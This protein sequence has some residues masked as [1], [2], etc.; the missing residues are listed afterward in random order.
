[1]RIIVSLGFFAALAMFAPSPASAQ[2]GDLRQQCARG[3]SQ[4]CWAVRFGTCA[5]GSPRVAIPACTRRLITETSFFYSDEIV[6][7]SRR[8]DRAQFYALRGNARARLGDRDRALADYRRALKSSRGIYW[9]HANLGTILFERGEYQAALAAFDEA[10]S[11]APDNVILLNARARLRATSADASIRDGAQAVDDASRAVALDG[12]V[13][14]F[15]FDTLAAA[16]AENGDFTRAVELQERV[17]EEAPPAA[18]GEY[19]ERLRLYRQNMPY[20]IAP[21]PGT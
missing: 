9:I 13:P 17:V 19:E 4:A 8:T 12:E 20:R 11:L 5:N 10:I 1:V 2:I 14:I 21:A 15:F 3:I 16:Y 6:G 7:G 18:R